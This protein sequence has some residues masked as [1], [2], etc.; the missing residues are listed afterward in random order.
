MPDTEQEPQRTRSID[1][2]RSIWA[3]GGE[4]QPVPP[5]YRRISGRRVLVVAACLTAVSA[6]FLAISAVDSGAQRYRVVLP[7]DTAGLPRVADDQ[8][9]AGLRL[10]Y[11]RDNSR[12]YGRHAADVQGYGRPGATG[13]RE[14]ELLAVAME[15][16]VPDAARAATEML[17]GYSP[18]GSSLSDGTPVTDMRTFEPGPLGGTLACAMIGKAGEQVAACSWADGS[19]LGHLVDRTG[20]LS[21][22]EM[23]VRTRDLRARTEQPA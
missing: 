21:L 20:E 6:G 18:Q 11:Q 15:G 14:S 7:T 3:A 5:W 12:R 1:S 13:L 9:L 10:S 17:G 2:L 8:E 16:T 4:P 23:A 19:T 22:D